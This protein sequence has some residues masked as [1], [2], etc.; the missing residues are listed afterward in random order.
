[1][2][3]IP[4][5]PA[6]CYR[7]RDL[8]LTRDEAQLFF[9]D[10]YLIFGKSAGK[11]PVSAFFSADVEGGDAELL[12]LPPLR[13]E[14]RELSTHTGS[15]NLEEH[16]TQAAMVFSGGAYQELIAELQHSSAKKTPEIGALLAERWSPLIKSMSASFGLRIVSDLLSPSNARKGFFASAL[17]GTKLGAFNVVFDP[18][19]PEQLLVGSSPENL[20]D[21]WASFTSRSFRGRPFSPEFRVADYRID[22]HLDADLMMH[23]TTTVTIT[24]A[25]DEHAVPFEISDRMKVTSV[26]VNGQAAEVLTHE[27]AGFVLVVP[28]TQLAGGTSV[29]MKFQHEG[30]VIQDAGNHVFSVGSRGTW[31]P[32][33]GR[34]FARFDMT[35]HVPKELDLVAAG[36]LIEDRTEAAQR[37]LHWKTAAPIRLAGFNLGIYDRVRAAHGDLTIEVCANKTIETGL[38]SHPAQAPI[39]IP[40]SPLSRGPRRTQPADLPAPSP[41]LTP[42][43][44][45][46]AL[47]TEIGEV[48]DFFAAKFG[49]LDL[50]RLEVTP[51]PGRFGQGFPGLIYLSTLSYLD[52]QEAVVSSLG[53]RQQTF[54]TD[55]LHA[56]EAAHQWWGNIV[57]SAEYHDDWLMEALANYSALLYLEKRKGAKAVDEILED[58]RQRL[59]AKKDTGDT[60]ESTGPVVQGTRLEAAWVPIV[61]GKGTWIIHMLRRQMG[62]ERFLPMLS[63]LRK[64]FE[65][66]PITTEE[67]R[68][69]AAKQLPPH[70]PD[71]KLE[72]FFDQWVY[73]T[74]IPALKVTSSLKARRVTGRVTQSETDDDFAAEVPLEIQMGKGRS[75]RKTVTAGSEP[76]DF[77]FALAAQPTKVSVDYR[78]ILHR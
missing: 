50:K 19:V 39:S 29:E 17:A 71:P 72:S 35:F 67:F 8:H 37:V 3:N 74:G 33:R 20:F 23:C 5:D 46:Q 53:Q 24:P 41:P 9:T 11:E 14:R 15:P 26:S 47:A 68:L 76:T 59:L 61:Y 44:R 63:D 70:S 38:T 16:F 7:V 22:T 48:M 34:Q 56:H 10:G 28:S 2:G 42:R 1:M 49:P 51:V 25:R 52:P 69:F 32:N 58:Y 78:S 6:E 64:A 30:K 54:F 65:D 75:V 62:D 36:D 40:Q 45:L 27:G 73:G 55:L 12:L 4:L 13:S 21:V 66:K 43:M 60:V 31:Y 77:E 18:R 57:I